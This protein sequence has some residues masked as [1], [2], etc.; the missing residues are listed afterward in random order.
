M[1]LLALNGSPRKHWS[2][3]TLLEKMLEGATQQ[4]A[5]TEL[6]HL[7]DL[8]FKG[9][10]SCFE[11]KRIGG[12]SYGRCAVS[13]GLTPVLQKAHEADAII[14]GTPVYLGTETGEMRSCFERLLFPYLSYTPGYKT[15]YPRKIRTAV[16]YTMNHKE[17]ELDSYQYTPFLNRMRN[18]MGNAFGHCEL[19]LCTDTLQF[20]DYDKY[21]TEVWD[22]DAKK[23]RHEEVFPQDCQRAFALGQRLAAAPGA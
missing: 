10:K 21:L 2:T 17:N 5:A 11:C 23:K 18:M 19:L 12:K 13:D 22:A 4:G 16:V 20:D 1:Y 8:D 14:L 3:A 15:L 6:V 9:C 7:Y